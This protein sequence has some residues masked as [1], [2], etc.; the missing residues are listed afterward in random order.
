MP[1]PGRQPERAARRHAEEPALGVEQVEQREEVVLVRPPAVEEDERSLGL[2]RGLA[3]ARD[4]LRH[5]PVGRG[6]G[7]GV[8]LFSTSS[9][10]CSKAGGRIS[11]SPRCSGSSS[12]PNPGPSVASSNSTPLGSRK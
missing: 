8:S 11:A 2:A 1:P 10:R 4:E 5:A 9:R 3:P 7:S 12:I 6:L